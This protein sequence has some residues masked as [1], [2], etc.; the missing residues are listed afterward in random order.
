[1]IVRACRLVAHSICQQGYGTRRDHQ[2]R[3][4][5]QRP[6]DAWTC[7]ARITCSWPSFTV[8]SLWA[9]ARGSRCGCEANLPCHAPHRAPMNRGH[10]RRAPGH[11]RFHAPR[12]GDAAGGQ[13]DWYPGYAEF[14]S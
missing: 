5:A 14:G 11:A 2:A 8:P 12:A 3:Q 4:P 9:M 6:S 13:F 10:C 1:M 7:A